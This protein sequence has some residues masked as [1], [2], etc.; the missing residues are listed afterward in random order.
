MP[1]SRTK[2]ETVDD[3]II[4]IAIFFKAVAALVVGKPLMLAVRVLRWIVQR[5]PIPTFVIFLT[6]IGV[7]ILDKVFTD[8]VNP[9]VFSIVFPVVLICVAGM[10]ASMW[11]KP[12][13]AEFQ[14]VDHKSV[15]R[16]DWFSERELD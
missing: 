5:Y 7:L 4:A 6:A 8:Q 13:Y 15:P 11:P 9:K 14:P 3:W 2:E 10:V 1:D 12:R 16:D